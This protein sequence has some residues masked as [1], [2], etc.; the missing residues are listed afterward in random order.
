MQ[1]NGQTLLDMGVYFDSARGSGPRLCTRPTVACPQ[2][3]PLLPQCSLDPASQAPMHSVLSFPPL[4]SFCPLAFPTC[5]PPYSSSA[6]QT[7][8]N[9]P[10][11]PLPLPPTPDGCPFSQVSMVRAVRGTRQELWPQSQLSVPYLSRSLAL[12]PGQ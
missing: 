5:S 2:D 8:L 10:I 1:D 4:F 11:L 9:I 12:S 6:L 3:P 7:Q